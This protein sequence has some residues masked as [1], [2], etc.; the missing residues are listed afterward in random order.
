MNY[1]EWLDNIERNKH[2]GVEHSKELSFQQIVDIGLVAIIDV[3]V[4]EHNSG[5]LIDDKT[6]LQYQFNVGENVCY[7]SVGVLLTQQELEHIMTN[8]LNGT[9]AP[10]IPMFSG[11]SIGSLDLIQS[12]YDDVVSNVSL[13]DDVVLFMEKH[14]FP[15]INKVEKYESTNIIQYINSKK[16]GV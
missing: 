3:L 7:C 16:E 10:F 12:L 4:A 5:N 1:Q 14:T 15:R 13:K 6:K 11:D 8:K 9:T 2:I